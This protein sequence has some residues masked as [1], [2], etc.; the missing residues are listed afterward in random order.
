MKMQTSIVD[1]NLDDK[2]LVA[3]NEFWRLLSLLSN[4]IMRF[5]THLKEKRKKKMEKF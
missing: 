3:T 5:L 4:T 1:S 2:S